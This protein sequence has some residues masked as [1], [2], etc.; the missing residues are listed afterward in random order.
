HGPAVEPVLPPDPAPGRPFVDRLP[1]HL[2]AL[3]SGFCFREDADAVNALAALVTAVLVNHFVAV[4]K[5]V[6]LLDGNQP[7]LGKTPLARV[8]GAVLDGHDPS[9]IAFT[10]DD[11]ELGKRIC[12][13]LRGGGQSVLVFDNAKVR[14]GDAI[15][16]R[17]IESQS[18]APTIALRILGTSTN[19]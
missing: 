9:L 14:A 2:R 10:T 16:S 15:N 8:L 11:D 19:F 6:V 7:G 3:L 1:R 5:P 13:T 17:V 18:M 4:P 12:A